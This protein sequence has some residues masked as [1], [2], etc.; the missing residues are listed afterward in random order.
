MAAKKTKPAQDMVEV[1]L[2]CEFTQGPILVGRLSHDRGQVRFEYH[3]AWIANRHAFELDPGLTL[4]AEPFFPDPE[5]SNFGVFLDSSPDRWG[6]LP[7][8]P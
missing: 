8:L 4:D 7:V 5:Q 1:Y 3:A 2:D 6:L